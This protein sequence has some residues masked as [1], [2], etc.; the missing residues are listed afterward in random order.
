MH[1]HKYL[2]VI[3]ALTFCCGVLEEH[4]LAY[5]RRGAIHQGSKMATL[6]PIMKLRLMAYLTT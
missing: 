5:K 1:A 3:F 6:Y 4:L 2:A